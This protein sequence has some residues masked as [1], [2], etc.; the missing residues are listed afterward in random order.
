M[1]TQKKHLPQTRLDELNI[2]DV[3]DIE[4]EEEVA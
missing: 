4:L 3:D 2:D 1:L